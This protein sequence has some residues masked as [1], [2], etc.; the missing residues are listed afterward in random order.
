[1]LENILNPYALG[2]A[3][4][5]AT[6]VFVIALVVT[7]TL[8]K[9]L[10]AAGAML[11]GLL[12]SG[13][14]CT[15]LAAFGF[16]DGGDPKWL[17][18]A[19]AY[20]GPAAA[21]AVATVLCYG[22]LSSAAKPLFRGIGM[23][24][25]VVSFLI[26]ALVGQRLSITEEMFSRE[27]LSRIQS[28]DPLLA[29]VA[30]LEVHYPALWQELM[31]DLK[32]DDRFGGDPVDTYISFVQKHQPMFTKLGDDE[33][34]VEL[35]QHIVDKMRF[36]STTNPEVCLLI[37]DGQ[38]TSAVGEVLP[39]E[40]KLAEANALKRLIESSDQGNSGVATQE[41]AEALIVSSYNELAQNHPVE[42]YALL[43]YFNGVSTDPSTACLGYV[44]LS[45]I[46]LSHPTESY[47]RMSRHPINS[48]A[49][50]TI[51]EAAQREIAL[52]SLYA[53]MAQTAPT[54]PQRLDQAT[55][56]TNM[57]FDGSAITYSY[58]LDAP[59]DRDR[60]SSHFRSNSLPQ[61]CADQDFRWVL[62]FGVTAHYDYYG[63]DNASLRLSLDETDCP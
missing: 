53:E 44:K 22:L 13:S 40:Y 63:S 38:A 2:G 43:N 10:G 11:T 16:A 57:E 33:A 17:K 14:I 29:G 18:A 23:T 8:N 6:V 5:A 52:S 1:M 42:Y 35:N 30:A 61:I 26:G 4:G 46:L 60:L 7:Q 21:A 37:A 31:N 56:L 9:R 27:T 55:T 36:L 34:V 48:D 19:F 15:S 62:D 58:L 25:V 28:N 54:L 20:G 24:V 12:I 59:M 47:A 32:N 50:F 51:S 45:D 39:Y 3:V 49:D 41:E